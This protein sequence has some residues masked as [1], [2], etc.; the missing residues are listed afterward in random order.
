MV[1]NITGGS[2]SKGIARKFATEGRT[3]KLVLST[4][5]DERYAIVTHIYGG[6]RCA[7]ITDNGLVLQAI[8]RKKFRGRHRRNNM[9][10]VSTYVL[11][12]LREYEAPAYKIC[13]VLEV[14][15]KDENDRLNSTPSV[16]TTL[17]N[18]I[19][20]NIAGNGGAGLSGSLGSMG[21][22]SSGLSGASADEHIM[23]SNAASH[24]GHGGDSG[25]SHNSHGGDS[26]GGAHGARARADASANAG[27]A[28][29]HGFNID[30]I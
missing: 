7:V 4:C 23:F 16:D 15:S 30:D 9:I 12:G 14:Y 22:S 1:K 8:I 18:G 19:A 26:H 3:E 2:K 21:T 29:E 13:D 25:D 10:A 6:D 17:L 5:A 24:G 11:V 20:H 28:L 27:K